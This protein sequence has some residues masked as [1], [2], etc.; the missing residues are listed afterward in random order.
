MS[1]LFYEESSSSSSEAEFQDYKEE[2]PK[3]ISSTP[4]TKV[5][6]T[7]NLPAP[8]VKKDAP[9]P[10]P[11]IALLPPTIAKSVIQAQNEKEEVID[12]DPE[13]L[14]TENQDVAEKNMIIRDK[15]QYNGV[16]YERWKSQLTYLAKI[17]LESRQTFEKQMSQATR[18][19]T[20]TS[21]MYGW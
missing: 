17:D 3:I 20:F 9:L 15:T 1:L 11:P 2:A 12:I 21:Q 10:P 7:F 14:K 8:T 4:S 13:K 16:G 5:I 18:A 19:R 6:S